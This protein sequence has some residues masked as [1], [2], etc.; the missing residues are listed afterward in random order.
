MIQTGKITSFPLVLFGTE[1]WTPML[2]W[3]S[4]TVLADGKISPEDIELFHVTD[5]VEEA[6]AIIKASERE[7]FG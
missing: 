3:I 4:G 5:D 6:V 1:F 2:D 7:E